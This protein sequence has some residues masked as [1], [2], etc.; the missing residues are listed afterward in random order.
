MYYITIC[1][2]LSIWIDFRPIKRTFH[3]YTHHIENRPLQSSV[4]SLNFQKFPKKHQ[5]SYLPFHIF[6][7]FQNLLDWLVEEG[8]DDTCS[9]VVHVSI[10][11]VVVLILLGMW[12]GP[13]DL[14]LKTLLLLLLRWCACSLSTLTCWSSILPALCALV[15]NSIRDSV[16]LIPAAARL[17]LH[18]RQPI[19][20]H[21]R[22]PFANQSH[23]TVRQPIQKKIL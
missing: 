5:K 8:R 15:M 7:G 13:S 10:V 11:I 6:W 21:H 2:L 23:Y 22:P 18:T 19:K 20:L 3:Y 17:H 14:V 9:W 16:S 1:N 4:T 12:T